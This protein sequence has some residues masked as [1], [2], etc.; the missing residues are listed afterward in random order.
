MAMSL[1]VPVYVCA[2]VAGFVIVTVVLNK[3]GISEKKN[4]NGN[5]EYIKLIKKQVVF[6]KLTGKDVAEWFR[7][8]KKT[9]EQP[10]TFFIAKPTEEVSQIFNLP[11]PPKELDREH[12]LLQVVVDNEKKIPLSMRLVNFMEISQELLKVLGDNDYTV[13]T[14]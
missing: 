14:E 7:K 1:T 8:Q 9:Y 2:A 10:V 5:D 12:Y 13:V 4:D 3:T 6:D 11:A